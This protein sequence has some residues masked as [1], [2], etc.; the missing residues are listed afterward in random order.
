M[1]EDVI[2]VLCIIFMGVGVIGGFYH[3]MLFIEEISKID[4]M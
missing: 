1:L 3:S 4:E 2:L